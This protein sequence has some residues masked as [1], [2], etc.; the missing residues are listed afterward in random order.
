[1]RATGIGFAGLEGAW[2]RPACKPYSLPAAVRDELNEIARALFALFDVL[3]AS[4]GYDADLTT[5]LDYKA[6][7]GLRTLTS[8][9]PTLAL[10]PDF[11]MCPTPEGSL[12]LIATELEMC[13]AAHGFAH[14]MQIGYDLEPDLARA[15]AQFLDGRELLIVGTHQWSEFI[16]EQLAFCRAL[17]EHGARARVTYD[18]PLETLAR[19][20][21][22]G[23]RWQPPMFG[24]PAKPPEW[25]DDLLARLRAHNLLP[26]W[27]DGWPEDASERVVFRFGYLENFAPERLA[28]FRRWETQGAR[29]LNPAAFYLDSKATLAAARLPSVRDQLGAATRAVLNGCLPETV[30]LQP[31]NLARFEADREGWVL[32]F[33]GYDAQQQARG[34]RSLQIGAAHTRA[35]WGAV[36]R[37][38]AALP[39]PTVA[40]RVAHSRRVDLAYF[41]PAGAT[42]HLTRAFTRLRTFLFR[43]GEH[44]GSHLTASGGT[45]QVSEATDSV[46]APIQFI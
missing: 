43:G 1:M 13:P 12:R 38:Y 22:T 8:R 24:V 14:A 25:N 37:R 28:L 18:L 30:I 21:R 5:L 36:L 26:F 40:Q 6:P 23:Q 19:E 42:Q 32:K 2:W 45:M 33:S 41:D 29:F 10:R 16:I 11:Q 4:Y 9:A 46:Q 3:G 20:F 15:F 35:S 17:A 34:G 27:R 44:A 39:F 31:E 7:T